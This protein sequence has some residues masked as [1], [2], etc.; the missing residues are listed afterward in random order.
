MHA[1]WERD[2]QMLHAESFQELGLV[3]ALEAE[4]GDGDM[5]HFSFPFPLP[6]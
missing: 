3:L 1:T 6:V 4:K 5:Q 2:L